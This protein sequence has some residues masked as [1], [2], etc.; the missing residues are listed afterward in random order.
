M[1][2]LPMILRC[3][4]GQKAMGDYHDEPGGGPITPGPFVDDH[5]DMPFLLAPTDGPVMEGP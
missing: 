3:R 5:G 4:L 2:A 1:N